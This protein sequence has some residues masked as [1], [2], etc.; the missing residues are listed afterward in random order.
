[1]HHHRTS[2]IIYPLQTVVR[3]LMPNS[4]VAIKLKNGKT[5]NVREMNK[6][7]INTGIY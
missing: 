3:T 6:T 4:K 7:E 1:M 2:F 5:E